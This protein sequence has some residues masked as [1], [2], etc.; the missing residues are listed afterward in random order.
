MNWSTLLNKSFFLTLFLIAYSSIIT[1]Q[2]SFQDTKNLYPDYNEIVIDNSELYD[3][4]IENNGLKILQ[5]THYESM[6]LTQNGII[7]NKESFSYS[8]LIPLKSY[9]AYTVLNDNEKEKKLKVTQTIEKQSEQGSIFYN[10]VKERQ[11]TFPGIETGAKKVY[12][13]QTQ[14]LDP[15]LLH[16]FIF[17]G[18]LPI[19]NC[20]LEV[21]T[22]KNV[23]ID[24]KIFND[25]D[26][27]ITY[28]KT[29]K[30]GKWIHKWTSS[31]IKPSKYED[32]APGY[33]YIV[34]HVDFYI[35]EYTINNKTTPVLGDINELYNYYKSFVKDLNKKEDP[36]LKAL[37]IDLTKDKNNDEE[38]VKSIFYWVK[39]NIKYIAFEDGY[40]GFIPREASLVFERKFGDCKDMANLISTMSLYA[41]LKNVTIAWIGTRSIPYSYN[42]L[43][44][45]SVDNHMIAIFKK[46][47]DYVF[48]D[49]TD[50][51]TRY[52]IPTAFIQGKEVLFTENDQYKIQPVPVVPGDL[53]EIKEDV[54]LKIENSKLVGN[55]KISRYGYNR[56][57]VLMQIG[58]ASNK[59]RQDM[60]KSLV[61][62][63][64]NKFN[65]KDFKEENLLNKDLPYTINYN[66]DLD[67]YIVKVD[68]ETYV[69]L[70]LDKFLE[71]TIIAKDRVYPYEFE[72]L[73]KF[74][75]QYALEIPKNNTIKYLPKNFDL[76]NDYVKANFVYEL[77][78]NILY[79]NVSLT[80]KKLLLNKSDFEPWNATI[81]KL[82]TNYNETI[83]LLEK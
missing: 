33:L 54:I 26:K 39:N 17:G 49:G 57:H 64:N 71:K 37:A 23:V 56:S 6:I 22:D 83:I 65:L 77:K 19:Q 60:I 68:K 72:Y 31:N 73:T 43:A 51:E 80:V 10:D 70:F 25:P 29:E 62:K 13:Y 24:Y 4:S 14:F 47:N 74:S 21:R 11:L 58:D 75:T 9:E 27:T 50:K 3:I 52:G 78:N 42:D 48:L 46:D 15:H 41:G 5:D 7:N 59:T 69:N 66:F 55:A 1:A 28:S 38:K 45:P 18:V 8:G 32:N 36:D 16:K 12:H 30:K 76:D 40:E 20:V 44:T 82:K 63:G 53:N 34:P 79:L 2:K 61:L 35:K 67:N 81:K